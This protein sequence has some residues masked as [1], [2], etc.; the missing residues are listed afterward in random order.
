MLS[1]DH[2]QNLASISQD[3]TDVCVTSPY[4]HQHDAD[5]LCSSFQA[6]NHFVS[7][8]RRDCADEGREKSLALLPDVLQGINTQLTTICHSV[9]ESEAA[10]K[11]EQSTLPH[12]SNTTT[13]GDFGFPSLVHNDTNNEPQD[14]KHHPQDVTFDAPEPRKGLPYAQMRKSARNSGNYPEGNTRSKVVGKRIQPF[15]ERLVSSDGKVASQTSHVATQR[16]SRLKKM[17]K[18]DA[19]EHWKQFEIKEKARISNS[20]ANDISDQFSEHPVRNFEQLLTSQDGKGK[21]GREKRVSVED[22]HAIT[23]FISAVASPQALVEFRQ[24]LTGWR[25]LPM[26]M[27]LVR[28]DGFASVLRALR[29]LEAQTAFTSIATRIK[30]VQLTRAVDSANRALP[31]RRGRGNPIFLWLSS[32]YKLFLRAEYPDLKEG[33]VAWNTKLDDLKRKVRA[34]RRWQQLIPQFGLGVIGLVPFELG[35]ETRS[36]NFDKWFA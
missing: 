11:S 7:L 35:G 10:I 20:G 3:T 17:S 22:A 2:A 28:D 23:R 27:E 32:Q 15:R 6:W 4:L 29:L 14:V 9:Y 33:T 18:I 16:K 21:A 12:D 30:L 36:C 1:P 5:H 19:L 25:S 8:F 26:A 31:L 34:G 24:A 13:E